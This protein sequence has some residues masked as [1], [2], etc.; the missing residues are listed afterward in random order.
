MSAAPS[1]IL[2]TTL[3]AAVT[4]VAC[5]ND[6]DTRPWNAPL[7]LEPGPDTTIYTVRMGETLSHIVQRCD[8]PGVLHLAGWNALP[9]PDRIE[10][11]Q[12]LL[13]PAGTRCEGAELDAMFPPP[14][15]PWTEC[16][17][18]WLSGWIAPASPELDPQCLTVD[19]E[20]AVCWQRVDEGEALV[21]TQGGVERSRVR[22]TSY[23]QHPFQ[24]RAA[25][26]DLDADGDRE[27]V[28][29]WLDAIS[30]GLTVETWELVIWEDPEGD[31]PTAGLTLHDVSPSPLITPEPGRAGCDLLASRWMRLEGP[32]R[33]GGNYMVGGRFSFDQGEV[34]AT[35][36]PVR[37]RRLLGGGAR[38][39][40]T[41]DA[42]NHSAA[43]IRPYPLTVRDDESGAAGRIE[44]VSC[45]IDSVRGRRCVLEVRLDDGDRR[46][47]SYPFRVP[48]TDPEA[49]GAVHTLYVGDVPMPQAYLPFDAQ[50]EWVGRSIQLVHKGSSVYEMILN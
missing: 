46:L 9:D 7:P 42:L 37:A 12:R 43:E 27:L 31:R 11:G 26:H 41:L 16:D 10:G 13:M 35:Q 25:L 44:T 6:F 39:P 2:M 33:G 49:V 40:T 48:N 1:R 28:L 3:V 36:A 8:L 24:L 18:S 23:Y 45:D 17:V 19:G 5:S 50:Q 47:V 14:R 34:V 30:N 22:R 38:G 32:F 29:L 4:F 20:L 21:V 15:A